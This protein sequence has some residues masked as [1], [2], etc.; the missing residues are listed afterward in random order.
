LLLPSLLPVLLPLL[1]LLL[2]WQPVAHAA[3]ESYRVVTFDYPPF[4]RMDDEQRPG[5]AAEVIMLLSGEHPIQFVFH[6]MPRARLELA[7]GAFLLGMGTRNHHLEAVKQGQIIPLQI[8]Q[9]RFVFFYAKQRFKNPPNLT[10]LE[11]FRAYRICAQQGS[12]AS[13]LFQKMG[14][15]FDPSTDFPSLFRKVAANRCDFGL[16]VDLTYYAYLSGYQNVAVKPEA[17]ALLDFTVQDVPGDI[18]INSNLKD[19]P[20]LAHDWALA[21]EKMQKDGT[22]QR[23]AEKYFGQVPESFLKFRVRDAGAP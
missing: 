6:P 22:L 11:Q 8:G 5:Y 23:L 15:E 14:I 18:L 1:L 13:A 9:S 3:P 4:F 12:A 16:V 21:I 19:A 17:F 2:A 10:T 20:K 7:K